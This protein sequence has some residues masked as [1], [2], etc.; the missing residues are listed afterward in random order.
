MEEI[1]NTM[2]EVNDIYRCPRRPACAQCAAAPSP[3]AE[4][5]G[6]RDL[7]MLVVE[8]GQ[9]LDNIESNMTSASWGARGRVHS[10]CSQ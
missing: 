6:G 8:Q 1:E 5:V 9:Q 2:L 10:A 4:W 3:A 7:N